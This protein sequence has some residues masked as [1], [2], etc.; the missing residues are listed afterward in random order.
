MATIKHQNSSRTS[1]RE[2][3]LDHDPP[4]QPRDDGGVEDGTSSDPATVKVLSVMICFGSI[5]LYTASIGA[6]IPLLE[7]Y[8]SIQDAT[9]AW[10]FILNVVGYL[11]GAAN[12]ERVHL[13]WGRRGVAFI[14][15]ILHILG[16][17][18][19]TTNPPYLV[20]LLAYFFFG[21]G[22]GCADA[23]FCAWAANVRNVCNVNAVQGLIHGSFSVGCVIGPLIVATIDKLGLDW[24]VF[25]MIML[26][27]FGIESCV[28]VVAFKHDS[29]LAYRIT[30]SEESDSQA[31]LAEGKRPIV[32]CALFYLCYV[33][34]E[35]SLSAWLVTF[36][37]RSRESSTYVAALTSSLFWGGMA[38][39][40]FTLG[41]LARAASL[42]LIVIIYIFLSLAAQVLFRF[43]IHIALSLMLAASI[44]FSLGPMFPAGVVM[45]TGQLPK[46]LQVRGYS[47]AASVGQLGG[48]GAPFILGLIAQSWG[49]E[50]LLDLV[51]AMSILLLLI[52]LGF[53]KHSFKSE[54]E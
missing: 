20:T 21:I 18:V 43:N 31:T 15:A 26:G 34:I 41:P 48:A 32:Y 44:G 37:S 9:V 14:T 52:W 33:G 8:Y 27:A 49:I 36:M 22:T 4:E 19:L 5:G 23:G 50:R 2:P 7:R 40:R 28:L 6:L 25:Y 12:L 38:I 29:G 47:V 42:R 46:S 17:S 16:I 13:F 1:E 30:M 54:E 51:L 10:V 39:G 3:L 35:T 24:S 45:L 11:V 53:S